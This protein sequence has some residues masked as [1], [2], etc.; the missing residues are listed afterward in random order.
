[1]W[2]ENAANQAAGLSAMAVLVLRLP[3]AVRGSGLSVVDFFN[4]RICIEKGMIM[5]KGDGLQADG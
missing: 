5:A 1:M 2:Q 3:G 4:K